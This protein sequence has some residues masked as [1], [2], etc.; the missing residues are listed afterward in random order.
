MKK[1]RNERQTED[2]EGV[3][4]DECVVARREKDRRE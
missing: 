4:N 1:G 3:R 2:A